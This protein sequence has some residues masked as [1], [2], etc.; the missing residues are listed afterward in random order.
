MWEKSADFWESTEKFCGK[1]QMHI[2][3]FPEGEPP[4]NGKAQ[5]LGKCRW[6]STGVSHSKCRK[7]FPGSLAFGKVQI[8]KV[9]K[10]GFP[11]GKAQKIICCFWEGADSI[12][13]INWSYVSW[14]MKPDHIV[15]VQ[16]HSF[17]TVVT[18]IINSTMMMV[19]STFLVL[20]LTYRQG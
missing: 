12:I 9:G 2:C 5:T 7:I 14:T 3:T 6:E 4:K 16:W 19:P 13:M 1:V 18:L 11:S 10:W 15:F 8:P 17:S 20:C